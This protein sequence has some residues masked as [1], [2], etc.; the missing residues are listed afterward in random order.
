MGSHRSF[1]TSRS[2]PLRPTGIWAARI[3]LQRAR[4]RISLAPL[5]PGSA[6]YL[7]QT[8]KDIWEKVRFPDSRGSRNTQFTLILGMRYLN[9]APPIVPTRRISRARNSGM[10]W[11]LSSAV[12][13]FSRSTARTF[14]CSACN[15]LSR[16]STRGEKSSGRRAVARRTPSPVAV[17]VRIQGRFVNA[18]I[19]EIALESGCPKPATPLADQESVCIR[20]STRAEERTF[21][22]R[23]RS[24]NSRLRRRFFL[25]LCALEGMESPNTAAR[26]MN[27]CHAEERAGFVLCQTTNAV[28]FTGLPPK[29]FSLRHGIINQG[30]YSALVA[31]AIANAFYLARHLAAR[32]RAGS[33][34]A[35]GGA[36]APSQVVTQAD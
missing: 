26:L 13:L 16:P 31:T 27:S 8:G 10:S 17:N 25:L 2:G 5:Q 11:G 35:T 4:P 20:A 32:E 29:L 33:S 36:T 18:R 23:C 30:Q 21:S 7:D 19:S 34:V 9:R 24:A 12:A 28:F 15:L 14:R 1:G 6:G 22:Y 3:S